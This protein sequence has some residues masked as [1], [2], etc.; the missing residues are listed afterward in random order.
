MEGLSGAVRAPTGNLIVLTIAV[1]LVD[2]STKW[3]ITA[4]GMCIDG[5]I[6]FVFVDDSVN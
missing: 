2:V 3:I 5:F 1:M 6:S 4:R